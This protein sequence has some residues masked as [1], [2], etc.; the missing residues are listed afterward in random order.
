MGVK[1]QRSPY[2]TE[3]LEQGHKGTS[4]ADIPSCVSSAAN[5]RLPTES[6]SSP[7]HVAS[8]ARTLTDRPGAIHTARHGERARERLVGSAGPGAGL[9]PRLV[10]ILDAAGLLGVGCSTLYQLIAGGKIESS[11]SAAQRGSR[12]LHST[13]SSPNSRESGTWGVLPVVPLR[14]GA[15]MMGEVSEPLTADLLA[16]LDVALNEAELHDVVAGPDRREAAVL[17]EVLTLPDI[18][19]EPTDRRVLLRLTG[20]SRVVEAPARPLGRP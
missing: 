10:T 20:V 12:S 16:G 6:L 1:A 15:A 13:P 18:G 3:P 14:G 4:S 11:I 2:L 5:E 9:P 8:T 17:I 7:S 19:P